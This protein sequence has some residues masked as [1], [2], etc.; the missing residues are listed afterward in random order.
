M[1]DTSLLPMAAAAAGLSLAQM[2]TA[3]YRP[4]APVEPER[5]ARARLSPRVR[6][7]GRMHG[8][9]S[10]AA[11]TPAPTVA[12]ARGMPSTVSV[13]RI[14][15]DVSCTPVAEALI[16]IELPHAGEPKSGP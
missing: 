9:G 1:T 10:P 14:T 12:S 8:N 3:S 6:G 16:D 7:R 4:R 13:G 11:T 2:W 5:T 15:F